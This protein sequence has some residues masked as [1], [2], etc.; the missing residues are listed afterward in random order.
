MELYLNRTAGSWHRNEATR[1][2]VR[3]D[4]KAIKDVTI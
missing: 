3:I 2:F 1:L 4:I